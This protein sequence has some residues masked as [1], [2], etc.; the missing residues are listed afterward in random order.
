MHVVSLSN[1]LADE[2]E[3]KTQNLTHALHTHSAH[4]A[5]PPDERRARPRPAHHHKIAVIFSVWRRPRRGGT[6]AS[7]NAKKDRLSTRLRCVYKKR[8]ELWH[9][10][11]ARS[12]AAASTRTAADTPSNKHTHLCR[13][14]PLRTRQCRGH[15]TCH[16]TAA[17]RRHSCV[18]P[19]RGH[20]RE[21]SSR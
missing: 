10:A 16:A 3:T 2:T 7:T 12:C 14:L 21:L 9:V 8:K 5:A 19:V 6:A 20:A 13:E 18:T 15:R 17:R 11:A 4:R 1:C